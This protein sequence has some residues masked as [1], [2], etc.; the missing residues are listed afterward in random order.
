MLTKSE[1]EFLNSQGLDASQVFDAKGRAPIEVKDEAKR[2]GKKIILGVPCAAAGHRL[3]TRYGHC[4]QCNPAHLGYQNR[5]SVQGDVYIAVS[6]SLRWTKVGSTTNRDQRFA[7]LN[8]DAYGTA[9]DWKPVFWVTTEQSG[10]IELDVHRSL[11]R[12]S[13]EATYVKDGK[14]QVSRECFSC[15]AV[16]AM[17]AV[18]ESIRRGRYRT[19]GQW[20]DQRHQWK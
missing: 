11:R 1:L 7:K 3:R 16:V 15:S 5:A 2:L 6:P 8:F 10:K 19:S 12:Y 17:N 20:M 4:A 13:V 9:H 14:P 18:V